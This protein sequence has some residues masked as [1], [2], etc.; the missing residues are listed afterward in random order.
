MIYKSDVFGL[1]PK[2]TQGIYDANAS[3]NKISL[4]KDGGILAVTSADGHTRVYNNYDGR[5]VLNET[6][7]SEPGPNHF[8]ALTLSG[9]VLLVPSNGKLRIY[10]SCVSSLARC[11]HCLSST[12]CLGCI[13]NYYLAD[14]GTCNTCSLFQ[15]CRTCVT[16]NMCT[17][18]FSGYFL[19]MEIGVC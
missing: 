10:Q 15:G 9:N 2:P 5:Y 4:R 11:S 3:I 17:S 13:D 7:N 19:N 14:S 1:N 12:Q 18:C 16:E 8:N 6:W